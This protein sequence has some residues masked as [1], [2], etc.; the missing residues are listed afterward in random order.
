MA[1]H[2]IGVVW[3]QEMRCDDNG[4][5][6]GKKHVWWRDVIKDPLSSCVYLTMASNFQ[7][8]REII[9]KLARSCALLFSSDTFHLLTC[10]VWY[11][12]W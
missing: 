6:L 10:G 4:D 8:N 1:S 11:C 9:N 7:S 5:D 2:V 3:L 12:S